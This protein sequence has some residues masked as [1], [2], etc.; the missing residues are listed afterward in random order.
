[1][2][3]GPVVSVRGEAFRE[4]PPEIARFSVTVAARDRDRRR[5]LARLGERA[6][7]VR[8]L[9]ETYGSA[10]ERQETGAL[11]VHPELK[12]SGER[13]A[14]YQGSV[15]TTVTVSDFTV[16][17]ELMLRLADQDQTTV[18]GPW[19]QLRPDS[20]IHRE[21]RREAVGAAVARAREY[22]EAL[23]ARL[24]GLIEIADTGLAGPTAMTRAAYQVDGGG[25]P[26]L[27]LDPE[28][29]TVHA[30][31]EA[32]FTITAPDLDR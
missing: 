22:A 5:T 31:V 19:W 26:E 23:G 1:M 16:L 15:T 9:V 28:Q 6:G 20:P 14:A 21:A 13:V 8:A 12:R 32:R 17:A 25:P 7:A 29:Q 2:V 24:T 30:T 27:D 4:V 18:T 11:R 10:V 3:T